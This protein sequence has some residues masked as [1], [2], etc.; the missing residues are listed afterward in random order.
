MAHILF[1]AHRIPY[2]P[3]K[4][5][6]I[7]SWHILRHMA[8]SHRISLGCFVDDPD[9]AQYESV[10]KDICAEV[11][12]LPLQ[13]RAAAVKSLGALFSS[14]SMSIRFYQNEAMRQWV[15]D[16]LGRE[17]IDYIYVFSSTMA[18]F[19]FVK[20]R[21]GTPVL[22]D[23]VDVDSQK[24]VQYAASKPWPISA[25]Y[26]YEGRA[27]LRAEREIARRSDE[28]LFV[29]QAEAELFK[30]LA[31]EVSHV[32][33]LPN[34]VDL[35]GFAPDEWEVATLEAGRYLVF[36]GAMDYWA[37]REAV[38]WFVH[39]CWKE[40]KKRWPDLHFYIVGSK[41]DADV[42]KLQQFKDVHVTG[43]VDKVQPYLKAADVIIAPLRIARGIQNKVLEAMAMARPIVASPEAAEGIEIT[44]GQ[45]FYLADGAKAFVDAIDLCLSDTVQAETMGQ[46]AR[47]KAMSFYSWNAQLQPLDELLASDKVEAAIVAAAKSQG[48]LDG[49]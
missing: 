37:N 1:L 30:S 7:R 40:L 27:L 33:A 31:P 24:W 4:G 25:L 12:C 8:K 49:Q 43:R 45:E 3:D 2:P 42:Q 36:T 6:K 39:E 19:A 10:L 9:D 17:N 22:M 34:G 29:S 28:N 38:Q 47:A 26:A 23:F 20:N 5:D 46:R 35:D 41:P 15:N 14:Q 44:H 32:D 18:Q 13:R 21:N 11:Q 48:E 16:L